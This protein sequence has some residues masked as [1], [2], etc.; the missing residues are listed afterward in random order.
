[1]PTFHF[2]NS[3]KSRTFGKENHKKSKLKTV[4][5]NMFFGGMKQT[6]SKQLF[7]FENMP[8]KFSDKVFYI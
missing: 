2:K 4:F 1:M 3:D 7:L 6:G 5:Y 8:V